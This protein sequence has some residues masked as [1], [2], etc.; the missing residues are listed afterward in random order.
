VNAEKLEESIKSH[1]GTRL[2][3]YEDTE[4]FLTIGFGTNLDAGI[5]LD[6]AYA[7]MRCALK[8]CEK[9]LDRMRPTWRDHNDARQNVLIEMM[10]NLGAK[11]LN[12]FVKMWEALETKD[13]NH[14]AL[15]MITSRWYEQVKGRAI[16]LANQMQSGEF[17]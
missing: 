10:Y 14:A 4:G 8:T 7:L 15:E 9:E 13:Y 5:T 11:K 2:L 12:R 6:Q 16:T 17:Q 3:P 1:E